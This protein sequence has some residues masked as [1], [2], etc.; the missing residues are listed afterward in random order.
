MQQIIQNY[1]NKNY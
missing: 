1:M